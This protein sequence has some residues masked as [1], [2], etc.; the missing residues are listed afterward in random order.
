[1]LVFL[2][3][4]HVTYNRQNKEI[5]GCLSINV[6]YKYN[7]LVSNIYMLEF[8]FIHQIFI[9]LQVNQISAQ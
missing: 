3:L 8:L 7:K 6:F 2:I 5:F 9:I 1:M 4:K